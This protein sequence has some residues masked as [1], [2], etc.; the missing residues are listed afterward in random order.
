MRRR[1]EK[2]VKRKNLTTPSG[3]VG[4]KQNQRKTT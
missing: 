1:R 3:R 4:N 2:V